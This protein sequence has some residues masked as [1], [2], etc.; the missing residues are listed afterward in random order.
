M[1]KNI[2]NIDTFLSSDEYTTNIVPEP[3][4]A[5]VERSFAKP[6]KRSKKM[7]S[8]LCVLALVFGVVGGVCCK[9]ITSL[10][11]S[12][13]LLGGAFNESVLNEVV[14][15]ASVI[16]AANVKTE[17]IAPKRMVKADPFLP[18]RDLSVTFNAAPKFELLEPPE[19]A[20]G[21]SDAGRIMDTSVSGILYDIYSPS[22]ILNIEGVDQLVKKGDKVN[23]YEVLEIER[24][25]VTVKLGANVY[26]A[27]IGEML[28]GGSLNH[29]KISNLDTKFGGKNGN[30]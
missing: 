15:E 16:A 12:E 18:Y 20:A 10:E 27:G 8:K 28:T 24:D 4:C 13:G 11:V 2:A 26:R 22:A 29:N 1:F 9:K 25:S 23:N 17:T 6:Q 30:Q 19:S 21:Y 5:F 14:P 3:D 7:F